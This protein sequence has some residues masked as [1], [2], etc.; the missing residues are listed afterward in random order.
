VTYSKLDYQS[1]QP[2]KKHTW[3]TEDLHSEFEEFIPL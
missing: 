2:D 1:I 3:L